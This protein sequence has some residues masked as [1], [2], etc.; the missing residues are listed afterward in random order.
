MFSKLDGLWWLL[1]MLG[2][3]IFLQRRLHFEVQ[4]VFLLLTRRIEISLVIFSLIFLPGVV[5]HEFSHW[6]MAKLLRVPTGGISLIPQATKDGRLQMGY[7]LTAQT[8]PVRDTLIGLAPLITGGVLVGWL[9]SAQI[10]FL[11]LW[12]ALTTADMAVILGVIEQILLQS[13]FWFWFYLTVA[14]SSTMMP[15]PADR[16]SWLP[17]SIAIGL[18]LGISIL[19][20]FG[21]WLME[22]LGTPL[23]NALR[24]VAIVFAISAG[25]HLIVLIP[26]MGFR[27]LLNKLTGLEV[28]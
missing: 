23:N 19:L 22:T 6:I 18:L 2:P 4:S 16:R 26:T 1:L 8:D 13:D 14:I 15:S 17:V 28:K 10:G 20:D 25:A 24:T 21:P 5:V 27:M 7:V 11:S 3:L 12:E 9:G